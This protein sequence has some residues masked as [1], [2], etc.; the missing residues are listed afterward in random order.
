MIRTTPFHERTS[1]AN[2]AGLWEHWSGYLVAQKYQLSE[3]FEYFAIRNSAGLFDSSPLFKYRI[4]GPDSEAFLAGVLARD[5]RACAVGHGQYTAWLDDGGFVVEDGV[6]FRTGMDDYLLTCA[7]PN[8]AYFSGLIGRRRVTIEDV[9]EWTAVLA[10]Q[11]P[12]SRQILACLTPVVGDLPYFGLAAATIGG[13]DVTIS[14]TG[15]TGDLGYELWIPADKAIAVWDAVTQAS[16]GRGVIPFGTVALYMARIEAGLLLLDVDFGSSRFAWTDA[17]RSTLIELGLG[18]MVRDLA[19][20]RTFIGRRAIERELR[21]KSSRWKLTGLVL[22]WQDY[23]RHYDD[24]GLIPPKDA[25]PVQDEYYVYDDAGTQLGYATSLMYSPM[26]QRHIALAR[27]PLDR[28]KPGS[29]VKLELPVNHRY[30]YFDAEVSRLPLYNPD[31]R[32][33]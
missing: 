18:W 13:A 29:R 24:A 32:T 26:L 31:R 3:K 33:A 12:T 16:E 17:N 22:D 23:D 15:Y 7:E 11:G 4:H 19:G 5:I 14:R 28:T 1:A 2:I 30:E 8:H 20:D 9:S 6:I 25:T 10:I 27:V 21:D